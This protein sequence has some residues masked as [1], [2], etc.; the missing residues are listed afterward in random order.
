[1]IREKFAK[2]EKTP[3]LPSFD[4]EL[5][6]FTEKDFLMNA[7][8]LNDLRRSK[9][10]LYFAIEKKVNQICQANSNIFAY[11]KKQQELVETGDSPSY[12]ESVKEMA[13]EL[14]FD[15]KLEELSEPILAKLLSPLSKEIRE[16]MYV[17]RN[18]ISVAQLLEVIDKWEDRTKYA[19]HVS[20]HKIVGQHINGDVHFSTDITKLFNKSGEGK[21]IY[22]FRLPS[23]LKG[24]KPNRNEEAFGYLNGS[25]IYEDVYPLINENDKDP[26]YR[27]KA[28]KKIGAGFSDYVAASDRIN[29]Y[30]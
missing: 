20:P 9:K 24:V 12:R 29:L 4:T 23:D 5:D 27:Q 10:I 3:K 1:M 2:K 21:Y 15:K 30:N 28:L 8:R 16:L 14:D 11:L 22:A 13:Q 7:D 19:F 18:K 26:L 25:V 6:Q 17:Q